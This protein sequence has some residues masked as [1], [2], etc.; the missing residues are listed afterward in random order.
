[1]IGINESNIDERQGRYLLKRDSEYVSFWTSAEVGK[2]KGS[3]VGLIVHKSWEKHI[4]RITR[5]SSYYIDALMVFRKTK[6]LIM[7]AYI[8]PSNKEIRKLLQQHIIQK[9]RESKRKRIKVIVMGDFNDIRLRT[10]DQS[11]E[12]S[13]RTQ[14]LPLIAWL[15]N[16][17]CE[18]AFRKVHPYKKEFTWSNNRTSSRIDYIWASKELS[19]SIIRCEIIDSECVTNSDHKIVQAYFITGISQKS[20]KTVCSKRAKGKKR[21]LRLEKATEEE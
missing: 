8:P 9:I 11:N 13:Q 21:V 7:I 4:G 17:S 12:E 18:D 2:A 20:R 3:G 5:C 10:L 19:Q 16:S 15:E 1:M 14:V 6:I